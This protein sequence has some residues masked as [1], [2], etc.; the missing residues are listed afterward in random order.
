INRE[1]SACGKIPILVLL[2]LARRHQWNSVLLHYSNSGDTTRDKDRVVGYA[3]M[4]FFEES[5]PSG[6]T[7]IDIRKE[8]AGATFLH[9]VWEQLPTLEKFLTHLCQKAGLPSDAWQKSRL[10]VWT[11]QVQ[12]FEE[13]K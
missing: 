7:A 13:K 3:A 1:N 4:A 2:E 10:E 12:Y 8:T 9:R 11:Y 6:S 5:N